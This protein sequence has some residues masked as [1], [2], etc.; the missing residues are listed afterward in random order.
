MI[1][2]PETSPPW[3]PPIGEA[4]QSELSVIHER[5]Y[6]ITFRKEEERN[7]QQIGMVKGMCMYEHVFM[8]AI[9]KNNEHIDKNSSTISHQN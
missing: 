3:L 8:K 7:R 1:V 2:F 9:P 5:G 6:R 4:V